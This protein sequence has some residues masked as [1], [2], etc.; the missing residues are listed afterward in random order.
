MSAKEPPIGTRCLNHVTG[1]DVYNLGV[2]EHTR[3]EL[4]TLSCVQEPPALLLEPR[5]SWPLSG[6]WTRSSPLDTAFSPR[7]LAAGSAG[8][9]ALLPFLG[10][11]LSGGGKAPWRVPGALTGQPGLGFGDSRPSWR[12][13]WM[14]RGPARGRPALAS[15][16]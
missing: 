16:L 9:K 6:A 1:M 10:S 14:P 2:P 7:G 5:R 8:P 11:V 12:C 15:I 3:R 13:S 4:F